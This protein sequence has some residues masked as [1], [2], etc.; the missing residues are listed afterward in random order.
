[1][2]QEVVASYAKYIGAA[3]KAMRVDCHFLGLALLLKDGEDAPS[4]FSHLV[5]Q[6]GVREA[7]VLDPPERPSSVPTYFSVVWLFM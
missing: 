4:L 3:A 1:M 2:L 5:S 7:G 6:R